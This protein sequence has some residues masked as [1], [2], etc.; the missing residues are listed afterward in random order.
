[1]GSWGLG[2]LIPSR[3]WHLKLSSCINTVLYYYVQKDDA[4][5]K[6]DEEGVDGIEPFLLN[7]HFVSHD[8]E[9]TV[10]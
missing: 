6:C 7:G 1:M 9:H 10:N 4:L 5:K 3:M 2:C 8:S